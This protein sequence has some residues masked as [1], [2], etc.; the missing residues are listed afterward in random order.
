MIYN[1]LNKIDKKKPFKVVS[2]HCDIP[3]KIY[4][5]IGA[6][7][8]VLTMIRIVD[9]LED[10]GSKDS[11]DQNDKSQ[12]ARLIAQKEEH[13]IKVKDEIRVIWG[14]YIKQPQI[15]KFPEIHS[16]VHNIMLETSKAK[17]NISKE[18]T[19]NLLD[20]VNRFAEIFWTTKNIKTFK[21]K[22]PY[23]PEQELVYPDLK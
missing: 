6:Q 3:C 11:I 1:I 10:L 20:K 18:S 22:S 12:F 8:S 17:Q 4:D 15:E 2:A 21:A 13:G 7:L 16:L 9:L 23:P 19:L 14:D 5:P